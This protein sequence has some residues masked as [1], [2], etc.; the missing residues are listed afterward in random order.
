MR[1]GLQK[2]APTNDGLDSDRL[3]GDFCSPP[4][5]IFDSG[6]VIGMIVPCNI[7]DATHNNF[8]FGTD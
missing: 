8:T 5:A 7:D 2:S 4:S 3:P 6:H 1:Q